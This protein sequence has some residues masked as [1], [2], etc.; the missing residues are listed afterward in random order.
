MKQLYLWMG[1]MAIAVIVCSGCA[2]KGGAAVPAASDTPAAAETGYADAD[3]DDF[4]DE[5]MQPEPDPLAFWNRAVFVFND[6]F[7]SH[8]YRLLC[9]QQTEVSVAFARPDRSEGLTRQQL[10][11]RA[12]QHIINTLQQ[13]A[14]GQ[15]PSLSVI[16]NSDD[17]LA[18]QES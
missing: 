2:H 16:D 14:D 6:T 8:A 11:N 4:P 12:R 10:S 5:A 18:I 7:L 15:S 17:S 3:P 1:A 13:L 9:Q